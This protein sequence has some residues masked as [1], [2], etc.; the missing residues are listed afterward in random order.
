MFLTELELLQTLSC[1]SFLYLKNNSKRRDKRLLKLW[2]NTSC[3]T[4]SRCHVYCVHSAIKW[5]RD[6]LYGKE[7]YETPCFILSRL[8]LKPLI[9]QLEYSSWVSQYHI[10]ISL[11]L[12]RKWKHK[13][14]GNLLINTSLIACKYETLWN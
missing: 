13:F 8:Q 6:F 11:R 3:R 12:K 7:R 4:A 2:T 14:Q 1:F 9:M 5:R 10:N